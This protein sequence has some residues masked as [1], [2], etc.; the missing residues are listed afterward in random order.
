MQFQFFIFN[1]SGTLADQHLEKWTLCGDFARFVVG[2]RPS[3]QRYLCISS[4]RSFCRSFFSETIPTEFSSFWSFATK[5]SHGWKIRA[6]NIPK[7]ISNDQL[8]EKFWRFRPCLCGEGSSRQAFCQLF[9]IFDCDEMPLTRTT[10]HVGQRA[11]RLM[12]FRESS[13][14][15]T[16]QILSSFTRFPDSP[17]QKAICRIRSKINDRVR[18]S[19]LTRPCRLR[20]RRW[21]EQ[22]WYFADGTSLQYSVIP[23]KSKSAVFL[24]IYWMWRAKICSFDSSE[25]SLMS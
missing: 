12:N 14:I 5:E 7:K 2:W 16:Q 25:V 13:S 10:Y 8:R 22:S 3:F 11:V 4:D 19:S 18:P 23:I 15:S 20:S 21:F 24:E 17:M 1:F 6:N 9:V